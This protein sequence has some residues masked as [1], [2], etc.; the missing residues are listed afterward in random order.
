MSNLVIPTIGDSG[1]YTLKAPFDTLMATDTVYTCQAIRRIG[2]YLAYNEDVYTDVYVANGL[3]ESDFEAD[4]RLNMYIVSLQSEAGQWLYVPASFIISYPVSN[5]VQY[6]NFMI[7][8]SLGALPVDT[9][10]SPIQTLIKNV[11]FQNFGVTPKTNVVQ[12]S[13]P[14]LVG[15]LK[16]EAIKTAR[17]QRAVEKKTDFARWQEA[18]RDLTEAQEKIQI[19]ENYIKEKHSVEIVTE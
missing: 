8:V 15:S 14:V 3:S 17:L 11:V 16:H 7:G 1:F 10:L 19:L 9:D 4:Q 2:D 18:V 5:G 12:L 13:K 6:Q